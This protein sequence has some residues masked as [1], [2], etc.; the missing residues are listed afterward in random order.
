MYNTTT[1]HHVSR[2][3][4][5]LL[6]N[7][8]SSCSSLLAKSK[9]FGVFIKSKPND[10]FIKSVQAKFPSAK[11]LQQSAVFFAIITALSTVWWWLWRQTL[12]VCRLLRQ[13]HYDDDY[14]DKYWISVSAQDP[15][16]PAA[17]RSAAARRGTAGGASTLQVKVHSVQYKTYSV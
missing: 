10:N 7:L 15:L 16:P 1:N 3:S 12:D 4:D 8:R 6:N 9:S 13:I 2:L 14:E 17:L 11:S 5:R